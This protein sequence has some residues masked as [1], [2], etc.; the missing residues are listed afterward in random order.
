MIR[1]RVSYDPE[2]D[3]SLLERE[4]IRDPAYTVGLHVYEE[5]GIGEGLDAIKCLAVRPVFLFV[6]TVGW[7]RNHRRR[8]I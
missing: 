2:N 6:N 4:R 8:R 1:E 3:S 5:R 7:T